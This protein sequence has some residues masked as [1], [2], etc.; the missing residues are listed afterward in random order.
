MVHGSTFCSVFAAVG[1]FEALSGL[2]FGPLWVLRDSEPPGV[3]RNAAKT[4]GSLKSLTFKFKALVLHNLDW[5]ESS[6]IIKVICNHWDYL[7]RFVGIALFSSIVMLWD[8]Q[9][10]YGWLQNEHVDWDAAHK[11]EELR[12]CLMQDFVFF[13]DSRLCCETHICLH[14]P[15]ACFCPS[16]G[17]SRSNQTREICSCFIDEGRGLCLVLVS[18]IDFWPCGFLSS[19]LPKLLAVSWLDIPFSMYSDTHPLPCIRPCLPTSHRRGETC[20]GF[21]SFRPTQLVAVRGYTVYVFCQS[22]LETCL[23]SLLGFCLDF[24]VY[25]GP[26]FDCRMF[27]FHGWESMLFRIPHQVPGVSVSHPRWKT[28]PSSPPR[29]HLFAFHGIPEDRKV[30]WVDEWIFRNLFYCSQRVFKVF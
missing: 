10:G 5:A 28:D 8:L 12:F 21:S 11:R 30:D 17:S 13:P 18:P 25:L 14:L 20:E 4:L 2:S 24:G 7:Y 26:W 29:D 1:S 15:T 6:S 16:N 19:R 23:H 22:F 9:G 3:A 27:G